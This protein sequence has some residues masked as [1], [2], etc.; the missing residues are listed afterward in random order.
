MSD[1]YG[2][3]HKKNV[4]FIETF[5]KV[6]EIVF[7]KSEDVHE[8]NLAICFY[9]LPNLSFYLML[10]ILFEIGAQSEINNFG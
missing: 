8:T 7:V 6:H 10:E 9:L 4:F 5:P 3:F 2:K 1:P